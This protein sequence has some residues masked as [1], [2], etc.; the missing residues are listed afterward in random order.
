MLYIE[1]LYDKGKL[2]RGVRAARRLNIA[3]RFLRDYEFSGFIPSIRCPLAYG[4][5]R[6]KSVRRDDDIVKIDAV[7]R[8]LA[9]ARACG[10]LRFAV[11]EHFV[12]NDSTMAAY[13]RRNLLPDGGR[14]A[15]LI[16]EDLRRGL[17]LIL[18]AYEKGKKNG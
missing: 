12:L 10:P 8:Y 7:D 9:G 4:D 6:F 1:K 11:V 3:L 16:Y 13:L 18:E 15:E 14:V 2:G 17:D 5:C